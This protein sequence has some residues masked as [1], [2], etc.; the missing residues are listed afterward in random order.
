MGFQTRLLLRYV[1]AEK[2]SLWKR[3]SG[4]YVPVFVL[5]AES[6]IDC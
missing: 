5:N 3:G 2:C 4:E 6:M 1:S